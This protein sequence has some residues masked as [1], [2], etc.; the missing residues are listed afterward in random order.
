M[1]SIFSGLGS[2]EKALERQGID[3]KLINYCEID[4]QVSKAYS[5]LH[6]VS[7]ELNLGD[8]T[9]VN[10]AQLEDFDLMTWGFPCQDISIAGKQRGIVEGETRS[11]LYY[12]GLR[13]LKSKKPKYSIIE[14]VKALVTHKKFKDDFIRILNDLDTAGYNNYFKVLDSKNFGIP[15]HRER[16]FIVSIRKD[17]DREF[18]FKSTV[19]KDIKIEDILKE[20][21]EQRYYKDKE[22]ELLG[23]LY[24]SQELILAD[25]SFE[26]T[27]RVFKNKTFGTLTTGDS[28]GKKRVIK[29]GTVRK[30]TPL[31]CFRLMDYDDSDYILLREN[32]FT[33][34]KLYKMAGNS[35]VVI[36]VEN[37]LKEL[38]AGDANV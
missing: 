37:I 4:K 8:I 29:N 31:E 7:E 11:G 33:D 3:Y 9:K 35:I 36:V 21:V 13:I 38:L 23:D 6:N 16:V 24:N 34:T 22:I 18:N 25:R 5:L 28:C 30:L 26:T 2:F 12:E 1:L 15:Q 17:I 14:N 32:G 19:F 27:F 10:A 20:N